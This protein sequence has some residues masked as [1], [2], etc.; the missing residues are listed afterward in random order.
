VTNLASDP[1]AVQGEAARASEN[2]PSAGFNI[3]RFAM[4]LL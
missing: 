1:K 2:A 4:G 3:A